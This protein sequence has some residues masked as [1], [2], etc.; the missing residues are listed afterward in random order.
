VG[1]L[2]RHKQINSNAR[3][4]LREIS[5]GAPP[6]P[7]SHQELIDRQISTEIL[8]VTAATAATYR[9]R[10]SDF[11]GND[12][13]YDNVH[14]IEMEDDVRLILDENGYAGVWELL[15]AF[16]AAPGVD[17]NLVPA[18][19]V[20]NHYRWIVWKLASMDRM[21]FGSIELPRYKI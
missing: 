1:H 2:Y 5:G 20:E 17:P 21:K 14:G 18:R 10:C 8:E 12:V 3:L 6:V 7:R 4:S 11:Y 15:R 13:T 16:L 19:W 9:F